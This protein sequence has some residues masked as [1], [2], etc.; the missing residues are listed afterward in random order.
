[1]QDSENGLRLGHATM[2]IRYHAG[3]YSPQTVFTGQSLT[4]LM[5]FQGIDAILPAGHGIKLVM[6][7][8]GEDYLAPACGNLCPINVDT[9]SSSILS[10]PYV[11]RDGSTVFITPQPAT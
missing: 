4:M 5:E 9:G 7:E 10:M 3:G 6:T 11:D 1:M 8:T 2:D